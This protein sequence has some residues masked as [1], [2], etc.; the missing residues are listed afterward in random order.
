MKRKHLLLTLLLAVLVP[1]AAMGQSSITVTCFAP[2]QEFATGYTDGETKTSGEM[3]AVS[4]GGVQGW[5]KFDVSQIPDNA[6]IQAIDLYF[7]SSSNSN[8][9]VKLTSA[10]EL[11]PVTAS[12]SDLYSAIT[13][14][15]P[16]YYTSDYVN[17][18]GSPGEK[19]FTLSDA[20]IAN[21]QTNGLTNNYF[22]L[23]FFEFES[24]DYY[25]YAYG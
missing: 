19:H 9:W 6:F 2:M 15:S 8:C 14:D 17:G 21:L 22:T 10:G 16:N 13:N 18:L 3:H 25:L 5:M 1:W 7:H 12:A 20:A 4:N 11:D 24:G 23:G